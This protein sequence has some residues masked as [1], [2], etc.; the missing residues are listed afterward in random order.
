MLRSTTSG[1]EVPLFPELPECRDFRRP[2]FAGLVGVYGILKVE[3]KPIR[4][5]A[6]TPTWREEQLAKRSQINKREDGKRAYATRIAQWGPNEQKRAYDQ[7]GWTLMHQS[8][9]DYDPSK[10]PYTRDKIYPSEDFAR[11]EKWKKWSRENPGKDN[12]L[13]P[14]TWKNVY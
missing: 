5:D 9:A 1:D 14:Y 8:R 4:N 7:R 2:G 3:H 13:N 10:N 6:V 12:L 11:V